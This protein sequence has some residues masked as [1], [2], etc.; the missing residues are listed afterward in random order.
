VNRIEHRI[1]A[2]GKRQ[3]KTER[4]K[5]RERGRERTTGRERGR[6]KDR[7]REGDRKTQRT[8]ERET[9]RERERVVGTHHSIAGKV[10]G[11]TVRCQRPLRKRHL[12]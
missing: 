2:V 5:E 12:F 1:A 9:G 4:H 6:E 8:R 7:K 10:D 3:R 11:T